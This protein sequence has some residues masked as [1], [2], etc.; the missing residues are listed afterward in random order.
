MKRSVC[1]AR[2][3]R[4]A[5]HE[6]GHAVI[7]RVL[8]LACDYATINADHDSAGHFIVRDPYLCEYE[9]DRRYKLRG[10]H[11]V[12]HARII[13]FPAGAEAERELA[14][15]K[16]PRGDGRRPVSDRPHD[17]RAHPWR[18][19]AMG[20]TGGPTAGNDADVSPPSPKANRA[21][22]NEATALQDAARSD[23]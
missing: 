8:T 10:N 19:A 5:I 16:T 3:Y 15:V 2:N 18:F 21:C 17:G 1:Q 11:A 7:A 22:S 20:L 23:A 13:C 12:F 6:A 14:G 9:W 4:N